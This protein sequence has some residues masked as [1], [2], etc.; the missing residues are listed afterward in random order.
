MTDEP[1]LV[2]PARV[3]PNR[4]R[5]FWGNLW[6]VKEDAFGYMTMSRV[7]DHTTV[8]KH[9][10]DVYGPLNDGHMAA[11]LAAAAMLGTKDAL[12]EI[13]DRIAYEIDHE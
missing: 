3:M 12:D 2:I 6:T 11:I 1:L 5:R 13:C 4:A 7:I 10:Q 9:K 8:R